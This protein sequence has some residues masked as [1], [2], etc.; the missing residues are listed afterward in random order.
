[1]IEWKHLF[2][3]YITEIYRYLFYDTWKAFKVIDLMIFE[4]ADRMKSEPVTIQSA[5]T[6]SKLTI[7]I[8]EQGV[9]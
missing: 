3:Y 5:F 6:C 8:L 1:M 9:K 2:Y 7:V 4:M